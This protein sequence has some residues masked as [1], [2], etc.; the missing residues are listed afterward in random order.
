MLSF[1]YYKAVDS[2]IFLRD[3]AKK[4]PKKSPPPQKKEEEECTTTLARGALV[5]GPLN[6]EI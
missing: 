1:H 5:S 3:A 2:H 6:K 4:I